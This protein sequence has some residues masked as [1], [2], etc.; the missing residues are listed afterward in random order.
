M[1][2]RARSTGENDLVV[3]FRSPV[4]YANAQSVA[5]GVRPRPYPLPYDAI[6][7][8]ACSFGWDW[9]IA[10]STSGIWRPVRLES[11]SIARLAD[12]RVRRDVEWSRRVGVVD[13]DVERR[14]GRGGG[15]RP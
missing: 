7:K 15:A 13:V 6:R 11:W 5:L 1:T 14:P 9:G 4:R 10:T 8:S 2:R 3:A 12:V